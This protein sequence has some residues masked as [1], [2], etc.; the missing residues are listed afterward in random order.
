MPGVKLPLVSRE[1]GTGED[2]DPA[3]FLPSLSPAPFRQISVSDGLSA[4]SLRPCLSFPAPNYFAGLGAERSSWSDAHTRAYSPRLP[5]PLSWSLCAAALRSSSAAG[6]PTPLELQAL[7]FPQ[8][9]DPSCNQYQFSVPSRSLTS[10]PPAAHTYI[11]HYRF[12][13]R[14]FVKGQDVSTFLKDSL[15][16]RHIGIFS[17]L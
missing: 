14:T 13:Y 15:P 8:S 4:V 5:S 12:P 17:P 6:A 3:G 7:T 1:S 11:P 10:T 9:V 2:A 16:G